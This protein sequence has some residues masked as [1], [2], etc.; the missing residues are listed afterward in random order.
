MI[1]GKFIKSSLLYTI[2]GAMPM[3]SGL[4]LLPFYTNILDLSTYGTLMLYVVFSLFMQSLTSYA[5]DAY[6]NVHYTE[7][8]DNK[9]AARKLIGAVAGLLLVIGAITILL[10][11]F[12]GESL[13]D[14]SFNRKGDLDFAPWGFMSVITGFFNGFFKAGTNLLIF[15]QEPGRFLLFNFINFLLTIG[16]S[17]AGLYMY[18]G[19][20]TGPMYGR[21]LSG[22]GIFLLTLIFIGKEYGINFSFSSIKGLHRFCIPYVFYLIL[23][24]LVTNLDRYI[25]KD[26]LDT[27][28]VGLFDFAVRCTLL[29]SLVQDGLVAAINP[30]VYSLWRENGRNESTPDA[31]RYFNVYSALG[32][33]FI[34]GFSLI[35]PLCIPWVVKDEAYYATFVFMGAVA[36]GFATRGLYHYF[37]LKILYLKKTH[38]L[39]VAFGLSAL[40]QIPLTIFLTNEWGLIGVVWA[41]IAAKAIQALFLY[42]VV[43]KHFVIRFNVWKMLGLPTLFIAASI[44]LWYAFPVYRWEWYLVLFTGTLLSVFLIYRKE[45]L[46][47]AARFR[48]RT[49]G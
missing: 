28:S 4:V 43:H 10:S 3:A 31:N 44:S 17:L 34:A 48:K 35:I 12:F 20:I 33:L 11:W 46:I 49:S 29:I 2:G 27:A 18:P 16:I 5:L 40:V 1:S 30:I 41:S 22:A 15:R 23:V 26:A 32:V 47:T 6:I 42:V 14:F 39:T 13:F 36:S 19:E 8:K 24:W 21:L 45:I 38:L 25:I 7:V 37:L 9:A